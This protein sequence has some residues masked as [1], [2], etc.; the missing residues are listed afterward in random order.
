[1]VRL[2]ATIEEKVKSEVNCQ[3]MLQSAQRGDKSCTT[4]QS[5]QRVLQAYTLSA[6]ARRSVM[7]WVGER[8]QEDKLDW[9]Y[10]YCRVYIHAVS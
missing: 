2:H 8:I 3:D 6:R 5:L 1:M 4:Y 9:Y 7:Q 10:D